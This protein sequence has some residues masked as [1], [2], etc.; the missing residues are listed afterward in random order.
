MTK[1]TFLL[2]D[3]R[4]DHL[5]QIAIA[6]KTTVT[7]LL[8]EGADLVIAKYRRAEDREELERRARQA[9][10]AMRQGFYSGRSLSGRIDEVVYRVP[11]KRRPRKT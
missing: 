6:N 4:R 2:A 9:A 10:K 7:E 1:T 5:K 8:A 3:S 11:G